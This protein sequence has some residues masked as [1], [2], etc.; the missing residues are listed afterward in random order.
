MKRLKRTAGDQAESPTALIAAARAALGDIGPGAGMEDIARHA[1]CGVDVLYRHFTDR[2]ELIDAVLA[3]LVASVGDDHREAAG[4]AASRGRSGLRYAVAPLAALAAVT[5][6]AAPTGMPMTP[7]PAA[8]AAV[9]EPVAAAESP[10]PTVLTLTPLWPVWPLEFALQG[11]LCQSG[12]CDA[13]PYLPFSTAAGVS[14]LNTRLSSPTDAGRLASDTGTVV[15]GYS[16]G[17]V[18][19]GRWLA[20]YADQSWAPPADRLSFVLIGNPMRAHG[21][22]KPA[23]PHT[24]YR[25]VD[26]VRQY[27]PVADFPDN[28]FNLF[29]MLNIG[30]GILSSVHLDYTGVDIDDPRNTVWTEDNI[31]YVF[32]PTQN[33][34]LLTP[35]RLIG[36]GR[37]ADALNEPLKELVEQAYDRPYLA[38][39]EA[40]DPADTSFAEPAAE[41]GVADTQARADRDAGAAADD[42]D[43]LGEHSAPI[44][45]QTSAL[46]EDSA[47]AEPPPEDPEVHADDPDVTAGETA[48]QD[49]PEGPGAVE[50]EAP[51]TTDNTVGS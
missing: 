43:V 10:V 37:L 42:P 32:V 2:D 4:D 36:L 50:A 45:E 17:A 14:L 6:V 8:A 1:G 3:D 11:S 24:R 39:T 41:A 25:V 16:H 29:A 44:G 23:L 34:P 30:A 38:K 27:D 13:V 21:G 49:T 19:A 12:G 7:S 33:L 47:D 40:T 9:T 15:F 26:V 51:R 18:V 31:T 5:T 46:E 35:L 22:T 28:P 48:A 20:E